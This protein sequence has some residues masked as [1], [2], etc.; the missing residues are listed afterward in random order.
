MDNGRTHDSVSSGR[1]RI[2]LRHQISVDPITISLI[3]RYESV[4]V[5]RLGLAGR[6]AGFDDD[7]IAEE[8][9]LAPDLIPHEVGQ[10]A[11]SDQEGG[12]DHHWRHYAS[13]SVRHR[14]RRR[15]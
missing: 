4:V 1:G 13:L 6:R 14:P 3:K 11:D 8:V 9:P 12:R 15:R 10:D 5:V 7:P 2:Q